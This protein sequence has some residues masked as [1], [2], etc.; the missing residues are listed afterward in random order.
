MLPRPR[1]LLLSIPLALVLA[2]PA[3]AQTPTVGWI[4]EGDCDSAPPGERRSREVEESETKQGTLVVVDDE[5]ALVRLIVGV[6]TRH[7]YRV[8]GA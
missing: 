3:A 7:G 5:P 1:R 4:H 6:L 8:R 2:A